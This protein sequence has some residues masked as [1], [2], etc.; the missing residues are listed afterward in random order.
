MSVSREALEATAAEV[1]DLL[2]QVRQRRGGGGGG[3]CVLTVLVHAGWQVLE[4]DGDSPDGCS[5]N[6]Q[7]RVRISDLSHTLPPAAARSDADAQAAN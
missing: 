6:K 4:A 7:D 5:L 2:Y 1:F 3:G